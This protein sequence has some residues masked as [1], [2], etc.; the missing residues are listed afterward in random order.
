MTSHSS[1]SSTLTDTAIHSSSGSCYSA[2]VGEQS[3]AIS[4]SVCVSV[5]VSP[6]AYLLNHWIDLHKIFMQILCGRG[7]V[8]LWRRCDTL[9][10]SGFMDDVT[11]GR[12]GPYGNAWKAEPLAYYHW[13]R[14]DTGAESDV[15]EC[16]VVFAVEM[17][18]LLLWCSNLF[19]FQFPV[20]ISACSSLETNVIELKL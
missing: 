20:K 1:L 7:S 5:S 2:L 12:R 6:R 18:T 19:F 17:Q 3:I 15:Y 9:C 11:F 13:R 4:L 14:C 10:T 16:L 8:L